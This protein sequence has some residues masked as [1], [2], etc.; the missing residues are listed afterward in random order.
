MDYDA[1][2][3]MEPITEN[4]GLP[5]NSNKKRRKLIIGIAIAVVIVI[6]AVIGVFAYGQMTKVGALY[7]QVNAEN[8]NKQT[9]TPVELAIYQGDMKAQ[10][11]DDDESN[12]PQ[13][14]ANV[15]MDAN[16]PWGIEQVTERGTY[17]VEIKATPALEDG[18]LFKIPEIQVVSLE[19]DDI[20]T[21]FNLEKLDL[22]TASAEE[23]E[24]AAKAAEEAAKA[25]GDESKVTAASAA[26][27]KATEKAPSTSNKSNSNS[28]SSSNNSGS[29]GSSNNGGGST[30]GSTG[31]STGGSAGGGSSEQEKPVHE[32]N[33]VYHKAVT[34]EVTVCND[35]PQQRPS[36][37]HLKNHLLNGGSGGTHSEVITVKEAYY[38]C[39]CGATK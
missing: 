8:W 27:K 1:T 32:H 13:S 12:D 26:T 33:W 29:S 23:V 16:T 4:E 19:G 39:S 17:T 38:S 2:T 24:A 25:T 30:S 35:C 6:A 21:T 31:G 36:K 5:N 9:S 10:L 20:T 28:G 15:I 22:N 14:I 18:T 7:V 11:E 34:E 37:E 3:P